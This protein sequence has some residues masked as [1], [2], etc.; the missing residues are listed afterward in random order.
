MS[1]TLK[2]RTGNQFSIHAGEWEAVIAELG[3]SLR[4]LR[5]QGT[6]I[7]V[8]FDPDALIPCCNGWILAPYPNRCTDT[9][10]I[11]CG[12]WKNF[13]NHKSHSHGAHPICRGIP[14]M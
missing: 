1:T 8:P 4:V 6:D 2:P 13:A 10:T 11:T 5:W 9:P 7:V 14:S 12:N 3:A